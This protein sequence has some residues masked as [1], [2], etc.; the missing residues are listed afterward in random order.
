LAP[1]LQANLEHAIQ[2][3]YGEFLLRE[4]LG[5]TVTLEEYTARFPSYAERL[6]LRRAYAYW[7][8]RDMP[9]GVRPPRE[10][11]SILTPPPHRVPMLGDPGEEDKSWPTEGGSVAKHFEAFGGRLVR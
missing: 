9:N 7:S 1:A 11:R 5:E 10:M 4:E 8:L 6:K 3:V 2:L